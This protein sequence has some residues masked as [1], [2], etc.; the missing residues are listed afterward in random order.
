MDAPEQV[1]TIHRGFADEVENLLIP[2]NSIVLTPRQ[3]VKQFDLTNWSI[4]PGLGGDEEIWPQ[5]IKTHVEP[6]LL[7]SWVTYKNASPLANVPEALIM[8]R[9]QVRTLT[10]QYRR[11]TTPDGQAIS[12]H[13]ATVV[14]ME[15]VMQTQN[16]LNSTGNL[17]KLETH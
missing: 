15:E 2:P 8:T 7:A 5:S 1:V 13:S 4:A 9:D 12:W 11:L 3:K 14:E 16:I 6:R 10:P 17:D